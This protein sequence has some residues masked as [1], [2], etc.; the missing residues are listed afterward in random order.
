MTVMVLDAYVLDDLREQENELDHYMV[1]YE[2]LIE[3]QG[4]PY[5]DYKIYWGKWNEIKPVEKFK[6]A[7]Q[8]VKKIIKAQDTKIRFDD[9]L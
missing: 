1:E 3:T 2:Q 8:R 7:V 9:L 6:L 5:C 4:M